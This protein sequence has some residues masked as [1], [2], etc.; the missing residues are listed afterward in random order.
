MGSILLPSVIASA[1]NQLFIGKSLTKKSAALYCS[2]KI[3]IVLAGMLASLP[4]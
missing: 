4:E 3:I 2:I 1:N